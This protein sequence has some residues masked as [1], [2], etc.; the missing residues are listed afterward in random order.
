MGDAGGVVVGV[1]VDVLG[2]VVVE[3]E[4]GGDVDSG[5]DED[6]EEEKDEERENK[7]VPSL[8]NL[9]ISKYFL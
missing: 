9:L 8:S 6:G 5:E 2:V 3:V 4:L 1:V 7:G